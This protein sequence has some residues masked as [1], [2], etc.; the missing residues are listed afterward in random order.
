MCGISGI[1]SY[2]EH[3]G[4][5]FELLKRM[6]DLIIHRGPDDEGYLLVQPQKGEIHAYDGKCSLKEYWQ[7]HSRHNPVLGFGFR[8]LPT[9]ELQAS[10]HQ[11]MHDS[12]LNLAIIFNGEIYN[13]I[14]LRQELTS[15]GYKFFSKS[16][17]E[18][19]LKAY[20]AWGDAMQSRLN[21]MWAFAIWDNN[22]RRLLLSRDRFGIKPF[23]YAIES[24]TIYWGS[25]LK[26]LLQCPIS[27]AWNP[28]MLWRNMKINGLLAYED[29]SFWQE[30]K[31]LV[32]GH[33]ISIENGEITQS[34]YYALDVGTFETSQ[35]PFEDAVA[36][37]RELFLDSL[38][39]NLRCDV[40]VGATLSGGMDSGAIV[41]AASQILDYPMQTFSTYYPEAAA[42]DERKWIEIMV[43]ETGV[44]NELIAPTAADAIAAWEDATYLND[45]PVNHGFISQYAIMKRAR[46]RGVTVLL[47][48]HGSDEISAGYRH[49]TYR[50]F[51]DL[52]RGREFG[53]FSRE[54]DSF[55]EPNP[56]EN[57]A[58]MG[59]IALSS[60][61]LES[62]LY[63]LELK[64]YRFEPFAADFIQQ[65]RR[66]EKGHI[67]GE[68]Y[69]IKSSRLSNFLYNMMRNTSIQSQLHFE[70]R[71]S[72]GNSVEGRVPFLDYRLVDFVFSLP[73]HYK[74]QPP[75]RKH[76]HRKAMEPSIPREIYER[77]DKSVF[78]SPITQSW[79]R[80]EMKGF[81][82]EILHSIEFRKRGIWDLPRIHE[83]WQGYLKGKTRDAETLFNV[84]ALE[85]WARKFG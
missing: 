77:K 29:Q 65:A 13:H 28:A 84:I 51:A 70:D 2:K 58:T 71:M 43:R 14:E 21:G 19:I 10:G 50:Y 75:Y 7:E 68:I 4:I 36:H 12:E 66:Q 3:K 46:E 82:N 30:I 63:Y 37:Y 22:K 26:Q 11:P 1:Y 24:G 40:E 79:M 39:L 53:K 32:P 23:Y 61:C 33:Y 44:K 16:D 41:S 78:G 67:L 25:E 18:V 42:L 27:K 57:I 31:A 49:A 17:T 55:L 9:V 34:E 59:K 80:S 20:H 54:I 73:S 81:I 69:D 48:G 15:M 8:R 38:S 52:L 74:I 47:S 56:L 62:W 5:D 45:L 64:S 85:I 35:M 72:M 76:I 6:T 60:F 83:H